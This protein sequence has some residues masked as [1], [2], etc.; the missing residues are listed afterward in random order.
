MERLQ[1]FEPMLRDIQTQYEYEKKAMDVLKMKGREKSAPYRQYINNRLIYGRTG[2]E[3]I[4]AFKT[5]NVYQSASSTANMEY[6]QAN[7]DL[8]DEDAAFL[9]TQRRETFNKSYMYFW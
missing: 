8:D 7:W 5:M 3:T 4:A 2:V 1:A 6:L 9:D